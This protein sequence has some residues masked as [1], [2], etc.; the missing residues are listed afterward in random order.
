MLGEYVQAH[1]DE[2]IKNN[3]KPRALDCLYLRP[4]G[5]HQGGHELLTIRLAPIVVF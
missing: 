4:T 2:Q 5:N 3:N 1:D